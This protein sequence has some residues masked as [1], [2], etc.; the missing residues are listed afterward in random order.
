METEEAEIG[1]NKYRKEQTRSLSCDVL[2]VT[3]AEVEMRA[4]RDAFLQKTGTFERHITGDN[5]YFDLGV[6]GG[7]RILLVQS[8]MGAGGPG[9][10]TLVVHESIK[11][12]SPSAIVMV[13]IAFGLLPEEQNIGDILVSRQLS[14][15][16]MQRVEVD[17]DGQEV[18]KPRGDR[19]QAST[20]LLDRFRAAIYDWTGPKVHFGLI[21]SGEKLVNSKDFRDKL[22]RIEPEAIGGEMEGTG[23]YAAAYRN[24]VDW[25]LVKAICD[26]ADGNKDDIHQKQAAENAVHF[27]IH[28]LGQGGLAGDTIATH[29][30]SPKLSAAVPPLRQA[31]GTTLRT[32]DSH[33]S[34]VVALAWE[35]GGNRIASAGGDGLVRVWDAD[36]EQTL[37]TYR[38]HPWLFEKVNWPPTIYNIA[39]SPEGLRLASAGDG[40][41]VYVWDAAT[42]QTIA[43]YEGHSGLLANVSALAWSPD[44]TRIASACSAAGIDKTVHVWDATTG[45]KLLHY[46]SHY[47]LL[48]NF[49]VLALA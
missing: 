5:T 3:A 13:G 27:I 26:R 38:G 12:L 39:W 32:Y 37:L 30:A 35:P 7:A 20:R 44:G 29:S 34:W 46:D 4:V 16:E 36:T 21:L 10:A 43:V 28:V 9:G 48:P 6:I 31:I 2:L 33:S 22:L 17:P 18:I 41:K 42:G 49:S 40:T 19:P 15:Y 47:G 11:A 23:G 45:K 14:G 1:A 25:I 8:E 24:K